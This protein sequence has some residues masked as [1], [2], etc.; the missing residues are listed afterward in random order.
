M[1]KLIC[2]DID[3]TL[4][5]DGTCTLPEGFAQLIKDLKKKGI[6]FVAASGRPYSSMRN[7]FKEVKDDII[8]VCESGCLVID[9]GEILMKKAIE[10]PVM[11]EIVEKFRSIEGSDFFASGVKGAYCEKENTPMHKWVRDEY[12]ADIVAVDDILKVDDE[13]IEVEL[14]NDKD[15]AG[16]AGEEFLAKYNGKNGVKAVGAGYMWLVCIRSDGGKGAAIEK[17]CQKYGILPEEVMAFGDGQNDADMV[18]FAGESYAVKGAHEDVVKNAKYTAPTW[19]E[20]GVSKVIKE[21][22]NM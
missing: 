19:R 14:Y 18:K 2:S 11:E 8:F 16:A 12:K 7:L 13:I 1:I 4:I 6:M 3:G 17:I 15:A 22:L 5:E 21:R 9:K 20:N 10:R